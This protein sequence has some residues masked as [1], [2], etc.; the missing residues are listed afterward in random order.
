MPADISLIQILGDD[1]PVALM[2]ERMA[3]RGI[4]FSFATNA[5]QAATDIRNLI[6][7]SPILLIRPLPSWAAAL[8][9]ACYTAPPTPVELPVTEAWGGQLIKWKFETGLVKPPSMDLVIPVWT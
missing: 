2:S 7:Q 5:A 3:Q 1:E 4:P 9:G 8:P 6:R